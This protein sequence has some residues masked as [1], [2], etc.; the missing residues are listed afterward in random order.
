MNRRW[1]FAIISLLPI[2]QVHALERGRCPGDIT[3]DLVADDRV[4]RRVVVGPEP[5]HVGV[6]ADSRRHDGRRQ[7]FGQL[8]CLVA[9][10]GEAGLMP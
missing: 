10:A 1:L 9:G 4:G 8:D 7:A 6:L 3:G 2:G 5:D